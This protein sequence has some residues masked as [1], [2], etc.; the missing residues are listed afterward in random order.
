M[1]QLSATRSRAIAR[2]TYT[3]LQKKYPL[4]LQSRD[5]LIFRADLGAKGIFYRVNVGGF[6]SKENANEFC[7]ALKAKG[8]SCLVKN[9]PS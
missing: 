4:E 8:A 9:E 6:S 5:P 7:N 2:Q 1:V 3:N